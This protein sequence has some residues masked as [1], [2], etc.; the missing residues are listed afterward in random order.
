MV[1]GSFFGLFGLFAF[2]LPH[3]VFYF[4]D[5][6]NITIN[7]IYQKGT[8]YK[9]ENCTKFFILLV[10]FICAIYAKNQYFLDKAKLNG[11]SHKGDGK[12]RKNPDQASLTRQVVFLDTD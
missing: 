4:C 10:C 7:I 2:C 11:Y 9:T 6:K 12:N 5:I 8:F 3:F 1:K